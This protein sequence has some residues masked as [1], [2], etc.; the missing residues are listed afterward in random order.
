MAFVLFCFTVRYIGVTRANVFNNIR[1]VFTALLMLFIFDEQ[2]PFLKWLGI[3]V[4]I[5]G[6]FISQKQR[7]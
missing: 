2:L 1:P 3:V 5:V 4:I 7:K 6:L